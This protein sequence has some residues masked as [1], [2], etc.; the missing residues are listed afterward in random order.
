MKVIINESKLEDL[1]KI[2]FNKWDKQGYANYDPKMSKVFNVRKYIDDDPGLN[3]IG[4]YL[5]SNKLILLWVADW[6]KKNN[7]SPLSILD[8]FGM[9]LHEGKLLTFYESTISKTFTYKKGN[10]YLEFTINELMYDNQEGIITINDFS[11]NINTAII[12]GENVSETLRSI[13]DDEL[14]SELA[15]GYRDAFNGIVYEYMYENYVSK[16]GDVDIEF[17]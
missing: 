1:K 12:D 8:E 16:M 15:D 10:D 5:T 3:K 17:H 7:I 2:F 6:N 11:P 13:E 4:Y 14:W 9:E